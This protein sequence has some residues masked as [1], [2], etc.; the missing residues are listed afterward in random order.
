[1][2]P[3]WLRRPRRQGN[4]WLRTGAVAALVAADQWSKSAAFAWLEV[5]PARD[6][7][8]D[9]VPILGEWLN[10]H[11]SCNYGAAFGQFDQ[12][13]QVLV[14]GRVLAVLFLGAWLVL[15]QEARPRIPLV[16]LVLVL[17]GA[18]G[19][20]IDNLWTGCVKEGQPFLGV[21]DF[22]DVWFEPLFGMDSHFPYFNLADSCITVGAVLWI[23][24][25]FLHKPEKDGGT[26]GAASGA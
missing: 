19:N 5:N 8:S 18:F 15:G 7:D 6:Y 2:I 14:V 4:T 11:S 9:R 22:I 24:A 21:R 23:L 12:F 10:F 3:D 25:S 26:D 20:L 1:M 17:S 13:P 16:A